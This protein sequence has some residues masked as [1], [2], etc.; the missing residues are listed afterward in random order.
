MSAPT[1]E[2]PGV[3]E[4]RP[5]R[6][7]YWVIFFAVT[8]A[9]LAYFDRV[10][11]SKAAPYIMK[12]LGMT[13]YQM[14]LVFSCFALAYALFEIPGGW[15]GDYMGPRKVLTRIVIWWSFFT[16]SVGWMWNWWALAINQLLFGAGEAGCFPNLTKAFT[17]WLL[18][19]EKVRA[20]GIMWM[21]ARWGGAITPLL[22]AWLFQYLPWRQVFSVFAVMGVVWV[23]FFWR[24][25]RDDPKDHPSLNNAE[26]ALLEPNRKL[27][28]SHGNV[29]WKKLLSNRSV[30]LLWAQYFLMT[31]PWYFYITWLSTYLQE[32][33]KL[34]TNTSAVY[35]ILPLAFGGL[36][37]FLSGIF[38]PKVASIV[39]GTAKARRTVATTGFVLAAFFMFMV[40]RMETP[41]TAMLMMGLA[42]FCNDLV[43]P[44]AWGA[45]MDIGGKYAG[46]LSGSMN[47]FGNFAGFAA[48]QIGGLIL[49]K[50]GDWNLVLYAMSFAYVLGIFTW[51]FIDPTTP[52]EEADGH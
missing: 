28:G 24:W 29:P 51:P 30:R 9:M 38:L 10:A 46:T 3:S 20:Q 34:D 16:A 39:G 6:A 36:G 19:A 43:M 26:K 11:I 15:L 14:G 40:T 4:Q 1:I 8:L 33:R 32:N 2:T 52:M 35:A 49:D 37:C 44:A 5:T 27:V 18:P 42:S 17:T 31:Y 12:D 23:T 50:T 47:M 13:K 22:F 48:P 45:C 21:F 7:R 41:L 25:F